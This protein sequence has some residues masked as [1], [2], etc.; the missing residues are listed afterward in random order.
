MR[1]V[2]NLGLPLICAWGILRPKRAL[3]RE[4]ASAV[5]WFGPEE[6]RERNIRAFWFG[7][8]FVWTII[9]LSVVLREPRSDGF[10]Q[11]VL[12]SPG[13]VFSLFLLA[14]TATIALVRRR[15]ATH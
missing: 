10:A 12:T 14:I 5:S 11:H 8:L 1:W 3:P 7:L 13:F 9:Q 4:S 2:L 15:P 6:K